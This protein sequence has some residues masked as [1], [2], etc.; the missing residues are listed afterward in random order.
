MITLLFG[1]NSFE[2]E[3]ERRRLAAGYTG[4]AEKIDGSA[5]ELK[6][7]PELIMGG[8]LF[9]AERLVIV[10]NLADNPAL[11]AA[12]GDWLDKVSPDIHLVLIETK[13]DKRTRTYKA[14]HKAAT[15][16]EFKQW[17]ERD[18]RAAVQWTLDEARQ[19]GL[20]LDDKAADLI[21]RRSMVVNDKPGGA[22]IDQW[23]ITHALDKLALLGTAATPAIIDDIIEPSPI[24]NVFDLFEAALAGDSQRVSDMLKTLERHEEPHRL[25]GLLSGQAF[26]LAA[27]SVADRPLSEVAR[28]IGAHPYAL[29]KLAPH[30]KK[31]GSEGV[32]QVVDALAT[33]DYDLKT[34]GHDPWLLIE[35]ALLRVAQIK[36]LPGNT[37][38][39]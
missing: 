38:L 21:A 24:E 27:I 23:R 22:V 6:Q 14:L 29:S 19:R 28:D 18:R 11:W 3:G 4:E 16:K 39:R 26:Y 30:A 15:V 5:L 33:A 36:A 10:K 20:G 31:L 35:R 34:S 12:L 32:R 37:P 1:D 13:P 8:T 2:I 7:L 17:T 25:M 9:A